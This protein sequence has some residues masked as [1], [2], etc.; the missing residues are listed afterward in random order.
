MNKQSGFDLILVDEIKDRG[1][2][3]SQ[4]YR[5]LTGAC[6]EG[7]NHFKEKNGITKDKIS[8]EDLKEILPSNYGYEKFIGLF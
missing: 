4:D 2:V 3:T 8:I 1:Y 5:L 7:I 6:R